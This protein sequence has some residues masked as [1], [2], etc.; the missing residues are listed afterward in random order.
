MIKSIGR[1]EANHIVVFVGYLGRTLLGKSIN[2]L[3]M[4]EINIS[5]KDVASIISSIDIFDE[6]NKVLWEGIGRDLEFL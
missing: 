4:N 6:K 3:N 5:E 2:C 1:R